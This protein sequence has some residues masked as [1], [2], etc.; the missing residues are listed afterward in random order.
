MS[1]C[2]VDFLLTHLNKQT[3]NAPDKL[4]QRLC[5]VHL[6]SCC[7]CWCALHAVYI[8]TTSI[9]STSSGLSQ[10]SL[11][12]AATLGKQQTICHLF[13]TDDLF[14][15]PSVFSVAND[16]DS[17]LTR[18]FQIHMYAESLTWAARYNTWLLMK[19]T[20]K[21]VVF[22]FLFYAGAGSFGD[23]ASAS[24]MTGVLASSSTTSCIA[25]TCS[26]SVRNTAT[27]C[28]MVRGSGSS[29]FTTGW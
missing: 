27:C 6:L 18:P 13:T 19:M 12:C 15:M 22:S 1:Q 9:A 11:M 17:S 2:K 16:L 24:S 7:T 10:P 14:W 3:K 20:P 26:S 25:A 23:A 5:H 28:G 21:G 29:P 4:A 8:H